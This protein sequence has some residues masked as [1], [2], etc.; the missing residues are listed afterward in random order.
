[1]PNKL[2]EGIYLN[3]VERPYNRTKKSSY[4]NKTFAILFLR[5]K[6]TSR[7][8]EVKQA[9]NE[10]WKKY[11]LLKKGRIYDNGEKYSVPSGNLTVLIGY[12]PKIFQLFGTVKR[13]PRDFEGKQFLP[14]IG[15]RPILNGSGIRYSTER[16]DNFG[17]HEHL[18]IQLISDSQ[19]PSYRA[20]VET[21]KEVH[22]ERNVLSLT[23]FYTGFQRDDRRS[24]LGFHDEV[25]NLKDEDERRRAITIDRNNN[26]LLPRDFWTQGGTYL[27]FM[28]I[29][30][31]LLTWEKIGRRKQE[32]VVGRNKHTGSFLTGVDKKGR[33][34]YKRIPRTL[35]D[36]FMSKELQNHPD[37]FRINSYSS[38]YSGIDIESSTTILNQS[39]IGR[40]RH[41][42]EI[43]SKYPSS[44]RIFRQG[45]EFVESARDGVLT[46]GLNF[47]SFQN[48]PGRLFFI[49]SDTNWMGKAN[50]GGSPQDVQLNNLLSVMTTG[51]FFI[52]PNERPFPGACI[53][54]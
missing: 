43:D 54:N 40:S 49:L 6:K 46:A 1:M 30:I 8:A 15:S 33:P 10:L 16:H 24:W 28:R 14:A 45:F 32:L 20:I 42:D 41:I 27:A 21:W 39:H 18:V 19:L 26:N 5:T 31:D 47:V 13:I 35:R 51:I 38:K 4:R 7:S 29:A 37:Y 23:S 25:S 11:E 22:K 34:I 17:L 9:I 36:P 2:Q 12:G 53:F 44:R 3:G 48:D 52:P 50:F